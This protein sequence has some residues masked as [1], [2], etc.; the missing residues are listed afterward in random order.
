MQRSLNMYCFSKDVG[1][2][3]AGAPPSYWHPSLRRDDP[4]SWLLVVRATNTAKLSRAEGKSPI[5]PW[6]FAIAVEIP[7]A[8]LTPQ[9]FLSV[10]RC[11][12]T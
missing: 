11:P 10:S 3:A 8:S 6:S 7:F 9:V 1:N 4:M 2:R 5:A 12:P